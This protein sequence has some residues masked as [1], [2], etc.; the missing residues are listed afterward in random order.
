VHFDSPLRRG[1]LV[2][3]YKRFL[4]DVVLD[5]G[6]EVTAHCANPGSMKSCLEPGGSVW[7]SEARNPKRK[8]PWTWEIAEVAQR[9]VY[10]N[11]ARANDLVV[12]AVKHGRVPELA[13]YD[14]LRRE[15][16][17][18]ER[19]RVDF[20]LTG[21]R[22]APCYVEVKCVTLDLG[23]ARAAFP[24]AV[25][26]RGT[27]H[28]RELQ[29]ERSAGHRAVMFFC[30][31]REHVASVEPAREIDP[32]YAEALGEA[33]RAGVELLGYRC[34]VEL[35]GVRLHRPVPVLL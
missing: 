6:R 32:E 7:L 35:D 33:S 4:A 11:P 9:L 22:G 31:V 21:R 1:R 26:A 18:G 24:D 8:L 13:G 23:H 15:V 28:L 14:V 3:R 16:P 5:D 34:R 19:S 2:R 17:Y 29:R 27:R 10:V 25:T 20:V 30:V 12:E